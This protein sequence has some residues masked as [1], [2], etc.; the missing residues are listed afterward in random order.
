MARDE[1]SE[2]LHDT[3]SAAVVLMAAFAPD[4]RRCRADPSCLR[5]KRR[6]HGRGGCAQGAALARSR[7]QPRAFVVQN[8]PAHRFPALAVTVDGEFFVVA[9]V[10]RDPKR[11]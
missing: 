10:A 3:G 4:R 11:R 2:A 9:K 7:G 8:C 5:P 1:D 6:A